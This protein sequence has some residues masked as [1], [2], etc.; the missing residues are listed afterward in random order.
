[1]IYLPLTY[2]THRCHVIFIDEKVGEFQYEIIAFPELPNPFET[3]SFSS[4]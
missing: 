4:N 1:M 3:I 2:E